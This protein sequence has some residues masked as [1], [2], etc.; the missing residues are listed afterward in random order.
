MY[1]HVVSVVTVMY[2]YIHSSTPACRYTILK[3]RMHGM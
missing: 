3:I 1:G 2:I